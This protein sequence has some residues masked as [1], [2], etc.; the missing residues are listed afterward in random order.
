MKNKVFISSLLSLLFCATG[1]MSGVAINVDTTE[2]EKDCAQGLNAVLPFSHQ[3]RISIYFAIIAANAAW[4]AY[5]AIKGGQNIREVVHNL[6]KHFTKPAKTQG[7]WAMKL[8]AALGTVDALSGYNANRVNKKN[9]HQDAIGQI[10][11][12]EEVRS[13]ELTTERDRLATLKSRN[14]DEQDRLDHLNAQLKEQ[15]T[16]ALL[17]KASDKVT[18]DAMAKMI[19]DLQLQMAV[20]KR[21]YAAD[22]A[23]R[24]RKGAGAFGITESRAAKSLSEAVEGQTA[25]Q[26]LSDNM[27]DIFND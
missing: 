7:G 25:I 20:L 3:T 5:H 1:S 18:S 8:A 14:S 10:V 6:S 4:E 19:T 2:A 21:Q 16:R 27:S 17:L 23:K 13:T 11:K 22:L 26:K 24:S 9:Q 12:A 15:S